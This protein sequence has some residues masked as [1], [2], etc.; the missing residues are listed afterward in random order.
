MPRNASA[1]SKPSGNKPNRRDH[2]AKVVAVLERMPVGGWRTSDED[3]IGLRRG[4]GC[5][6]ICEVAALEPQHGFFGDFRVRSASDG[7]YEV[8]IRSLNGFTNSSGC[9]DHRVNA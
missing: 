9:A 6:E 4:R 1:A 7:S 3:E 8:E 2:K 5:T